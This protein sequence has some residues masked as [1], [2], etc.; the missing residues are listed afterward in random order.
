M[1][2]HHLCRLLAW[3]PDLL[4]VIFVHEQTAAVISFV[5]GFEEKL[6]LFYVSVGY[7]VS[8]HVLILEIPR[9]LLEI[10]RTLL[11]I[12]RTDLT[13]L[14]CLSRKVSRIHDQARESTIR[15]RLDLECYLR[16][17]LAT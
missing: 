1:P 5:S 7:Y 10:P 13:S 14:E 3:F 6:L 15:S 16:D 12:P 11:E 17:H 8:R 4:C 9:T 2:F